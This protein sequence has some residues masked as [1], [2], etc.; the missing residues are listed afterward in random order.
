MELP[1]FLSAKTPSVEEMMLKMRGK[2][3][4]VTEETKRDK[5]KPKELSLVRENGRRA[6]NLLPVEAK[7]IE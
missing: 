2:Q 4:G 3:I 1:V 6:V 7:N 5:D